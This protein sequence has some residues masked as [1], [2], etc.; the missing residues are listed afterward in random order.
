MYLVTFP[1]S[2]YSKIKFDEK[3]NFV[4]HLLDLTIIDL[5][6]VSTCGY[7][8]GNHIYTRVEWH[9]FEVAEDQRLILITSEYYCGCRF[10]T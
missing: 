4:R 5:A 9:Q 1:R 10:D 8:N 6:S 7:M 3:P 2:F